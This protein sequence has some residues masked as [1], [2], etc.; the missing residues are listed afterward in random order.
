M[1]FCTHFNQHFIIILLYDIYYSAINDLQPTEQTF[2][3][4]LHE[5]SHKINVVKEQGFKGAMACKDVKEILEKLKLKAVSKIREFVLQ[6][7]YQ[8]RKPMSNYQVPQN[9]LLKYR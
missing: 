5:L 6:K 4:Q 3:E 1:S 8:C 9:A 7:V 2:I